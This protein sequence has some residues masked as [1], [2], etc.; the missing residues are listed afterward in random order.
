MPVGADPN[1]RDSTITPPVSAPAIAP[2]PRSISPQPRGTGRR[3]IAV[4]VAIGVVVIVVIALVVVVLPGT[5]PSASS[6]GGVGFSTA[7]ERANSTGAGH[8][9]GPW[10]LIYATGLAVSS[11]VVIPNGLRGFPG[12]LF[13]PC[14]QPIVGLGANITV[15]GE[16]GAVMSGNASFWQLT[17]RNATGGA[18]VDVLGGVPTLVVVLNGTACGAALAGIPAIPAGAVSS[19]VAARSLTPYDQAFAAEF[20]SAYA[21]YGLGAASILDEYPYPVWYIEYNACTTDDVTFVGTLN[22]ST[23][24]V[25]NAGTNVG[26][27]GLISAG[28]YPLPSSLSVNG[29]GMVSNG[30]EGA[31]WDWNVSGIDNNVTWADL[32]PLITEPV[33]S[34]PPPGGN[35]TDAWIPVTSGWNLTALTPGNA[36]IATFDPGTWSWSGDSSALIQLNDSIRIVLTGPLVDALYLEANLGGQGQFL[37]AVN[38]GISL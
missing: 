10:S 30:T 18:V 26:S 4:V 11:S 28:H 6:G 5:S 37:G 12:P 13:F 34:F 14:G 16:P 9:G 23:S 27:C 17:Y 29:F 15:P 24:Y 33:G 38:L 3:W 36:S 32:L 1:A 8:G 22:V 21:D 19:T 20:P 35:V 31:V 25:L 2:T 7:R